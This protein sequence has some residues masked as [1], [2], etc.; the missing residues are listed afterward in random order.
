M[1]KR[2]LQNW[3]EQVR[4]WESLGDPDELAEA[5]LA[6]S[7]ADRGRVLA[8]L[9]CD[10]ADEVRAAIARLEAEPESAGLTGRAGRRAHGRTRRGEW[11]REPL[12]CCPECGSFV[13]RIT[14]P[15]A[16]PPNPFVVCPR[17][18]GRLHDVQQDR[19]AAA[20]AFARLVLRQMAEK[21][22]VTWGPRD[23]DT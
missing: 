17:C 10:V 16:T 19:K 22:G 18:G 2:E 15:R 23:G 9:S 21:H 12:K 3:R 5:M 7:R 4:A 1:T 11:H 13:T 6:L 8:M 14:L 20:R